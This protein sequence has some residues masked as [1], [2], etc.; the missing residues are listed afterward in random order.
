MNRVYKFLLILFLPIIFISCAKTPYTN[1]TQ[2]I[3]VSPQDEV[4][5]G[6]QAAREVLQKEPI[7]KDRRLNYLVR[8]VGMRI[9][10]AAN[11]P[12][13][14]WE[15]FVIDKDI[16]N[17]FCLP[18]GKVFVYKGI[19]KIA[20]NEDQLATVIAHEVAHAIL[21]HGAERMSMVQLGQIGKELLA[22][23][24][25]GKYGSLFDT[26]YGIGAQYGVILPYSRKF[27]YEADEVGLYLMTKAGYD[28]REAI[29]F[30]ENMMRMS[31]GQKPPEF[32]ST[33]PADEHRI[34]RLKALIPKALKY[35]R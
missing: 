5:M 23:T 3:M 18:G 10:K 13:Y 19:F 28:P 20:Q 27:E 26:V 8:K 33:H 9:A 31:R 4:K 35:Y 6:Y 16:P 34:Q 22:R 15:F 17:A 25:G 14:K 7:S 24:I 11:Q 2:L 32:L 21:R 12:N 29:K 30:W 1:R